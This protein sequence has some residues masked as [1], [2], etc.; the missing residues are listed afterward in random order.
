MRF[1]GSHG[2]EAACLAPGSGKGQWGAGREAAYNSG[3]L[4]CMSPFEVVP[5]DSCL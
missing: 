5:T 3:E 4:A 1:L 2:D